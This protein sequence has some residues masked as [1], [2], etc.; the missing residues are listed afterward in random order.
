[1]FTFQDQ[2]QL[3][4]EI[5]GLSD[6]ASTTRFKRD[7]N[8]GGVMFMAMLNRDYNR[9]SRTT[10]IVASQ[11]YYQ[12]PEDALRVR[13]A[14]YSDGNGTTIR[15]RQ[16]ADEENWAD[17]NINGTTGTPSHYFV[18]GFDEIGLYPTPSS[19]VTDGLELVF[20][21]KHGL[22]TQDDYTTGSI[23]VTRGSQTVTGSSTTFTSAMVGRCIEVTDGS[24]SRF[25]RISDVT[26]TTSLTLE[27]YY[28][29]VSGSISNGSWRIGEVMDLPDEFMEA[30]VDYAMYR[31]YLKRNAQRA[32]EFKSL[33]DSAKDIVQEMYGMSSSTQVIEAESTIRPY[34][35]L[36]DTPSAI[37]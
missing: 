18:R 1:M 15:L 21:P 8:R 34:N 6:T 5:T 16:V 35:F 9:K 17:L 29:G 4:Q 31:H 24:D 32:K 7:I 13:L 33:F 36:R 2:Y 19:S 37:T 10:N 23:T 3:A 27:N 26:N 25:Y 20:E 11:Q 28:Q 22:A 14:K 12:Y 30:P